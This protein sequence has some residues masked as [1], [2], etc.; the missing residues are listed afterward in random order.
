M[1]RVEAFGLAPPEAATDATTPTS[2]ARMRS[3]AGSRSAARSTQTLQTKRDRPA[4]R[5]EGWAEAAGEYVGRDRN[6]DE[7]L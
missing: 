4:G 3:A 5:L 6:F 7:E 1:H 2:P